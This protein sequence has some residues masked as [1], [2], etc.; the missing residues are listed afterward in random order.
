MGAVRGNAYA[1][2]SSPKKK[3][4]I[5]WGVWLYFGPSAIGSLWIIIRYLT[6]VLSGE[7]QINHFM[8][9][10]A[11]AMQLMIAILYGFCSCWVLWAVS[12]SCFSKSH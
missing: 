7:I 4:I 10:G 3:P 1:P 12:K 6:K 5:F 8:Q 2:V 9:S 11:E